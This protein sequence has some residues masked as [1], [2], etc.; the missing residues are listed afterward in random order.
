MTA[1][2]SNFEIYERMNCG[3]VPRTKER[4]RIATAG[5]C[6]SCRDLVA[7]AINLLNL[8]GKI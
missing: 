8:L 7:Q 4:L 3:V 2:L 5:R 1:F 6:V